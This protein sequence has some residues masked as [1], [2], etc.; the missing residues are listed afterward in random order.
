MLA[1]KTLD[2][3]NKALE[4]D[5][6]SKYRG[7]LK[8]YMVAATDPFREDEPK[9]RPHLG[10]S[11]LGDK[12]ER[13]LWYG[14][15]WAKEIT[16]E[17]RK[18][19]LFNRG[20]LEEP[21]FLALLEMIGCEVW[22]TDENG[23]Q[24]KAGEGYVQGSLDAV[25]RGI[26]ECPDTPLL[27]EFKT[28]SDKSFTKLVKEGVTQAKWEH[29]CQMQFYMGKKNLTGA[30]Y[31]AVNKNDDS[32]YAEIIDFNDS[33][34]QG[35]LRKAKD[36]INAETPPP[37]YSD[38]SAAFVCKYCEYRDICFNDAIPAMNCRTCANAAVTT[39]GI[40]CA[41]TWNTLSFE[42][43]INGCKYYERGF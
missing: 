34:H 35:L 29:Y 13:K 19:Q 17:G 14:F 42:D 22:A 11:L 39:D 36:I 23:G 7:L 6:G 15:H 4:V 33:I 3:I 16:H 9:F 20:H 18:L 10:A 32:L 8:K 43:Q 21:R 12:C 2:A 30:L 37:R 5:Q 26:P 28:H 38:N 24:W 1:T 25:I 27:A 40:A 41:E 31:L